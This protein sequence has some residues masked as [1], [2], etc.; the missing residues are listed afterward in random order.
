MTKQDDL[1]LQNEI[2]L[3]LKKLTNEKKV[4]WFRREVD[5]NL[6]YCQCERDLMI[7][8]LSD[9]TLDNIHPFD[10]VHGVT[11][12][13]RNLSLTW[14]EG[15]DD[16]WEDLLALLHSAKIDETKFPEVRHTTLTSIVSDL[17]SYGINGTE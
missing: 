9:G 7:F 2:V 5:W 3:L 6:V 14:L 11:L 13:V 17:N 16:V 1:F 4:Q 8:E 15:L 12:R 10:N